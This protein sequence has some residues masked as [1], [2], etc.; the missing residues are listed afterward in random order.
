[1]S[2]S[3]HV[4]KCTRYW[5]KIMNTDLRFDGIELWQLAGWT[6]LHF[7]WLGTLVGLVAG[8]CRLLLRQA[9]PNVRYATAVTT[10]VVLASLPLSIAAWLVITYPTDFL[11]EDAPAALGFAAGPTA[12][13]TQISPPI[14]Q[15]IGEIIELS[16]RNDPPP[17]ERVPTAP[18]S[19]GLSLPK[20]AG[21]LSTDGGLTSDQAA[22]PTAASTAPLTDGTRA[23][24][25]S[26]D[27]IFES[28]QSFALY[29]P[30]LWLIGTPITFAPLTTGLVGTRRLR[31]AS[32]P[33]HRRTDR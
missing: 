18:G 26:P 13:P 15:T 6:M 4:K 24:T 32:R 27:V 3:D 5:I 29:L 7:L 17:S 21:G 19:P 22:V 11:T 20:S 2:S 23:V 8:A 16:G 12:T 25:L 31:L 33:I 30:W 28:L 9:S 10:L 1:M 14:D